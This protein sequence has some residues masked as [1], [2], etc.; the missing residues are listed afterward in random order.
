MPQYTVS[1]EHVYR[2]QNTFLPWTFFLAP[3]VNSKWW[4]E[5]LSTR[6]LSTNL[7]KFKTLVLQH[8]GINNVL[9]LKCCVSALLHVL[10]QTPRSGFQGFHQSADLHLHNVRECFMQHQ[11]SCSEFLPAPLILC[12]P[13]DLLNPLSNY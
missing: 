11:V 12:A 2:Q 1:Q 4:R 7:T 13:A 6:V 10:S 9:M 3:F 5:P 8:A